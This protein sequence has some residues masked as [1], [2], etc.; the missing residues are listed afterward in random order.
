[1]RRIITILCYCAIF[2]F[3]ACTGRAK[4]KTN[5]EVQYSEEAKSPY[6]FYLTAQALPKLFPKATFK[7]VPIKANVFSSTTNQNKSVYFCLSDRIAF[8]AYEM[9]QL[10]DWL[11]EGNEAV[12]IAHTFDPAL[13][14]SLSISLN[15]SRELGN[16]DE[17]Q[18]ITDAVKVHVSQNAVVKT[19]TIARYKQRIFNNYFSIT[20]KQDS[21]AASYTILSTD[22]KDHPNAI[23]FRIGE[24]RLIIMS[25][26]LSFSNYFLLEDPRNQAYLEDMMAY[27]SKDVKYVYTSAGYNKTPQNSSLSILW[28]HMATRM[29]LI[30]SVL[31]LLIYVLFSLKRKQRIIP[32]VE[33]LKN[34]SASFVETIAGLYYNKHNNKN[35]A[36]KMIQHFFEYV[37][38]TYQLNTNLLDEV[39]EQKLSIRSGRTK[40]ETNYL[41]TQIKQVLADSIDVNDTFLHSFYKNMQTFYK[42]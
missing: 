32:V 8:S 38:S 13:L 21:L 39:F 36:Q 19:Y 2:A 42:K 9:R 11:Y 40:A 16:T 1:M 31:G 24:G 41:V 3:A 4:T 29:A 22:A 30:L 7:D 20:G 17:D 18:K 27:V 35:L 37:R 5:W 23:A 33:P 14:E 28:D 26:P 15:V 25:A 6:G 10:D 12:L 34:D